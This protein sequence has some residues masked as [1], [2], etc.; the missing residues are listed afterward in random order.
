MRFPRMVV[1]ASIGMAVGMTALSLL[2]VRIAPMLSYGKG[3]AYLSARGGDWDVYVLDPRLNITHNLT[4]N[5]ADDWFP[6]WSPDGEHMAFRSSRDGNDELYIMDY[7]GGNCGASP[8]TPRGTLRQS[9]HRTVSIW[10][11]SPTARSRVATSTFWI[12]AAPRN[13]LLSA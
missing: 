13:V 6:A 10:R 12:S 3:L 5:P 11:S 9:G 4:N 8:T 1:V 2:A 7:D